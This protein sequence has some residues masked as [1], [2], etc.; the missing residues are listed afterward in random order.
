[1]LGRL[2]RF[3]GLLLTLTGRELKARYRGSLLGFLWSLVNPLLQL[4]V[5]TLVFDLV[6]SRFARNSTHGVR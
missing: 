4:A 2:L 5:Y 6:S 3:R 1:M